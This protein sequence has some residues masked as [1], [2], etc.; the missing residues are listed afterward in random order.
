[1]AEVAIRATGLGKRYQRTTPQDRPGSFRE[2]LARWYRRP[3]RWLRGQRGPAPRETFWALKDVSFEVRHGEVLGIIGRNGAGKSTLL[4]IFAR[5]TEPTEGCAEIHG[6]IGSLLEVGTGF[7]HELTGRENIYLSGAILGMKRREIARKFDDIVAFS[8]CGA[9][10][11][12]PVKWYSSGM[13]MRLAFAVAAH[14]DPDILIVDEVLAVGDIAFQKKC[15]GK[16]RDVTQYGRTVLFVSHNMGV[17]KS[18]CSRAM[19]LAGG[20]IAAAGDVD[21]VVERYLSGASEMAK[22]GII[23]DNV[24]RIGTREALVRRVQVVDRAGAPA[25]QLYFGDPVRVRIECAVSKRIADAVVEVGVATLE[26]Q[27]VTYSGNTDGN[28]PPAELP[29]GRVTIEVELAVVLLPRTYTVAIGLHH[30]DGA[31]IDMLER[32][33]DFTVLN[34]AETGGDR[35]PWE[36]DVRGFVRPPARWQFPAAP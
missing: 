33:I 14:L 2:L 4:K 9:F 35:Y 6:R 19:L 16:M 13:Y 25:E 34:V 18:L 21:R 30:S 5:I 28:A 22:T 3:L 12:T 32:S 15:L 29:A 17:I 7:H 24:P 10:I 26:G 8:E 23:P 36:P 20:T 31:T 1:M 27:R 11:D